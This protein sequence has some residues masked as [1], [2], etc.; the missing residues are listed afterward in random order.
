MTFHTGGGGDAADS[1]AMRINSA[2]IVTKPLQPAFSVHKNNTDQGPIA[3]G[4]YVL[5]TW[6]TERFDQNADFDLTNNRFVAP[7][8]G[9]YQFNANI[10]LDNI[11]ATAQ[12]YILVIS[13][14]N[15]G[16][17]FI[18]PTS[19]MFSSDATYFSISCSV[20]ADMDTGDTSEVQ[21]RQDPSGV[22]QTEIEG[23]ATYTNF[24]GFL[25]C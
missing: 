15:A 11:D 20:L 25:A 18:I 21:I 23:D 13:T 7:V 22:V 14:S 16:Y 17:N 5:V 10:R 12:N 9:K 8:S 2:G 4:V 6:T 24:S 1:E 19:V 3:E